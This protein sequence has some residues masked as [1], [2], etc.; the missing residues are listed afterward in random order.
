MCIYIYIYVYIVEEYGTQFSNFKPFNLNFK[1]VERWI[2]KPYTFQHGLHSLISHVL[3]N[4]L[5]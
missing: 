5:M 1:A 4:V 3:L 2:D